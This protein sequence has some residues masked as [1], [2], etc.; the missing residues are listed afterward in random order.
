M[1]EKV[2]KETTDLKTFSNGMSR[3]VRRLKIDNKVAEKDEL[4]KIL[5]HFVSERK[6]EVDLE[7]QYGRNHE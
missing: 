7:I 6:K 1:R 3:L 2:K 5:T 4:A